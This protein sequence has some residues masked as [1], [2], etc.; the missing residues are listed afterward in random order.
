[1]QNS[2][3]GEGHN[4]YDVVC[5][6]DKVN[7]KIWDEQNIS[8]ISIQNCFSA[9]PFDIQYMVFTMKDKF[10]DILKTL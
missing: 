4:H 6:L 3:Y 8:D 9:I 5:K 7:H 1:M 2:L 10:G